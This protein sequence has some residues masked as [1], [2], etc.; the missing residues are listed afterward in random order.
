M[1][2]LCA[3]LCQTKVS[4]YISKHV[5]RPRELANSAV[6]C[7][8]FG[9]CKNLSYIIVLQKTSVYFAL[10]LCNGTTTSSV[11]LVWHLTCC[12]VCSN[13]PQESCLELVLTYLEKRWKPVK[14]GG[15]VRLD[16][17]QVWKILCKNN[18]SKNWAPI[19]NIMEV[20][21]CCWEALL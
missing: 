14:E 9:I 12:S 19:V 5:P 15:Q 6:P 8:N 13:A 16:K 21:S 3:K 7:N 17:K 18:K 11:Q 10:T 20:T 4:A 2:S 1:L